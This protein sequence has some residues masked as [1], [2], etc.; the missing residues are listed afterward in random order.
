MS[1]RIV[2]IPGLSVYDPRLFPPHADNKRSTLCFISDGKSGDFNN[3]GYVQPA[4]NCKEVFLLFQ[5]KHFNTNLANICNRYLITTSMTITN[6]SSN[7]TIK[8]KNYECSREEN[9]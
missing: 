2:I 9:A 1:S 4:T 7:N 8:W 5:N 3:S 6:I